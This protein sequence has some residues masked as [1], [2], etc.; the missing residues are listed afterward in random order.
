MGKNFMTK[1]TKATATKAK[2]VK[3][4]LIKLSASI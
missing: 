3:W 4:D 1:M 2:I